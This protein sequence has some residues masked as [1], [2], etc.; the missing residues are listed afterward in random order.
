LRDDLVERR[1]LYG[2][3]PEVVEPLKALLEK[4]KADGRST[5]GP[6]QPNTPASAKRRGAS[7]PDENP[8]M[9][10]G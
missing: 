6:R 2:E 4:Y 5:P 10:A 7:I 8:P 3:R 9:A 1:N